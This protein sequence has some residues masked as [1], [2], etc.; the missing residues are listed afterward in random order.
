MYV[1]VY[2]YICIYIHMHVY[3]YIHRTN[4]VS[5]YGVAAKLVS[6]DSFLFG[7]PVDIL[8][9]SRKCQGVPFSPI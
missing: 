5:T 9:S 1:C 6:V 2:I 4:G 7:T 3:A 8:S